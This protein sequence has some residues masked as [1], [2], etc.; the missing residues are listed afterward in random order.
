LYV[1]KLPYNSL[2][3]DGASIIA[4]AIS[5]DIGKRHRHLSVLDLGFNS[6]G[7]TGC[8][9]LALHCIAGNSNLQALC[10]AGNQFGSDGASAIAAAIIHGTGLRNLHLSANNIG[11]NGMKDIASSIAKN[12]LQILQ[13]VANGDIDS[14]AIRPMEELYLGSTSMTSEGFGAISLM[15]L[16]NSSL[17]SL[18]LCDNDIDDHDMMLLSQALT[19]NNKQMPLES[20][21]LS[22]NQITCQGVEYFMNAVWGSTTLREIKLD[23][24][25]I[26]DR[27][28]QLCAV[29]LTSIELQ[30]LDLSFNKVSTIGLKALMKTLTDNTS[31][32]SLA[33]AGIHIDQTASKAVSYAL[34]Y[35]TTLTALYLDNCST[36]YA[37]QRHIVAGAV[38][39]SRSSLR[40]FTGFGISRKFLMC[41]I[42]L[43]SLYFC[44]HRF[45]RLL[46]S[47]KS[48]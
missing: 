4:S 40:I 43:H 19:Q 41:F 9:S 12:E 32:Q 45:I 24:N 13:L 17:R 44:S 25:K 30:T 33:I 27:G 28:A 11:P 29:V 23:N 46:L 2:G 15:I 22:F 42:K 26:K 21:H 34:A 47:Q 37:S 48:Q 10:L 38:S 1:L 8:S 14:N 6:I 39:N 36:G 35:N 3:D 18:S 7:D 31:L 20:L 5:I 16:M